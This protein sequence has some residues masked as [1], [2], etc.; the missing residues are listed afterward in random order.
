MQTQITM[1][2][3]DLEA[4]QSRIKQLTEI[5]CH[6]DLASHHHQDDLLTDSVLHLQGQISDIIEQYSVVTSLPPHHL[7]TYLENLKVELSSLEAENANL[8]NDIANLTNT[9][10]EDSIRLHNNIEGL[11]SSLHF[12]HSQGLETKTADY[13]L[14]SEVAHGDSK[15]KI[16]ELNSQLEKKKGM[17]E[18]LENLDYTLKRFEGFLKIEDTLTGI[19]VI[20]YDG[21]RISLSLRTYVP[22]IDMAE[23][24]HELAIELL[25]GTLELKNAEIF[26]ND[27]YIGEIIV[28]AKSF[29]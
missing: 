27:V 12:I 6:P 25:D 19:K 10:L 22:E 23:Q 15:F 26:P 13:Q 18:S 20:E 4:I 5:H 2:E 28:A 7:D 16:S 9:Y 14:Q 24:N 29:V 21:N 3:L 17:L 1:G 11:N 8:S